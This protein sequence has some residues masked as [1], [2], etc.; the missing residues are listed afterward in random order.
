MRET[1]TRVKMATSVPTSSGRP[2]WA[3]P[4]WP[5]YSPSEF[6]RT[7]TQS[8]SL[9]ATPASG[10]TDTQG[11]VE[12]ANHASGPPAE[13]E[14]ESSN[15]CFLLSFDSAVAWIDAGALLCQ[16]CLVYEDGESH[17]AKLRMESHGLAVDHVPHALG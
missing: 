5:E 11:A 10:L 4:P 7:I 15:S 3:R 9:A 17:E 16:P 14:I 13:L 8:R 12:L 1:P 6:S 2:R